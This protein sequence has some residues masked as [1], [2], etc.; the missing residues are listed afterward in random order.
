MSSNFWAVPTSYHAPAYR[1]H[2]SRMSPQSYTRPTNRLCVLQNMGPNDIGFDNK[3]ACIQNSGGNTTNPYCGEQQ[4]IC[5]AQGCTIT[6]VPP[7][8]GSSPLYTDTASCLASCKSYGLICG[9]KEGDQPKYSLGAV[10]KDPTQLKC[11]GCSSPDGKPG[12]TCVWNSNSSGDGADM[13]KSAALCKADENL[14][15]GWKWGC[16][17]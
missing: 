3:E 1:V 10:V 8:D 17:S 7:T 11:Y 13:Y 14:H 12:D 9:D 4:A 5:T 2:H 6:S 16:A 15:C